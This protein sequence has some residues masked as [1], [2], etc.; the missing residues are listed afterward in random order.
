MEEFHQECLDL[1]GMKKTNF[2]PSGRIKSLLSEIESLPDAV[3]VCGELR[4]S[5]TY[6]KE[7]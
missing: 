2:A 7:W 5:L 3:M 6:I 1:Q 4:L